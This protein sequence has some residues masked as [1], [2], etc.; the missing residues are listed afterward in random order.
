[1]NEY[2]GRIT[3]TI[4]AEVTFRSVAVEA[5]TLTAAIRTC[6]DQFADEIN[7]ANSATILVKPKPK[8]L[9]I[10]GHAPPYRKRHT[11]AERKEVAAARA[12]YVDELRGLV[13]EHGPG[14]V[15]DSLLAKRR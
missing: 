12:D 6:A 4:E 9:T 3:Y 2:I 11:R 1:M 10:D 7:A 13:N 5:E 8:T 15:A 14:A